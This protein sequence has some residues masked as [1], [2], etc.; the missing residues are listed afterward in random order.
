MESNVYKNGRV[1]E[2]ETVPVLHTSSCF[3]TNHKQEH[4]DCKTSLNHEDN[5]ICISRGR[6]SSRSNKTPPQTDIFAEINNVSAFVPGPG[7]GLGTDMSVFNPKVHSRDSSREKQHTD[8][9]GVMQ[10]LF[11]NLDNVD[12]GMLKHHILR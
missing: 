7:G 8:W 9:N 1:L 3:C 12:L 2:Y 4:Y 6:S 11:Y 10:D 5:T